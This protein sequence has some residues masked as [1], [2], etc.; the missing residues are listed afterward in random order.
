MYTDCRLSPIS[1]HFIKICCCISTI[2]LMQEVA[3]GFGLFLII[4]NAL[5][6]SSGT[7]LIPSFLVFQRLI[8]PSRIFR[9]YP[10]PYSFRRQHLP[11]HMIYHP[12]SIRLLKHFSKSHL[13]HRL[14]VVRQELLLT[15]FHGLQ[16]LPAHQHPQRRSRLSSQPILGPRS[17]I[18]RLCKKFFSSRLTAS[19]G[20]AL[21]LKS[22]YPIHGSYDP[23]GNK[24]H[25]MPACGPRYLHSRIFMRRNPAYMI[26]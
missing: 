23:H 4:F 18:A 1:Y 15:K 14:T 16:A 20:S 8:R 21:I 6:Y 9:V 10:P 26:T 5:R 7:S 22:T 12:T 17:Q 19:V 3:M 13:F 25:V 11:C 2:A 24:S